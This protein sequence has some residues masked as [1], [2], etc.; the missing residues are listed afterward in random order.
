MSEHDDRITALRPKLTDEFLSTLV[1][2]ADLGSGDYMEIDA[3]V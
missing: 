3:F 2:A 1:E